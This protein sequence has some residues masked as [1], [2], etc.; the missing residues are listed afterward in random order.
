MWPLLQDF[1]FAWRALRRSPIHS[2]S[3]I[4]TMALGI[5]SATAIFAIVYG[6]LLR[7]LPFD[8]ADRVVQVCEISQPTA[9]FCVVSP[10][11]LADLTRDAATIEAAGVA[12]GQ[13]LVGEDASG[14]YSVRGGLATPGLFRV[15]ALRPAMGRLLE[16]IDMPRGANQVVVVSHGF[17]QSRLGGSANAVGATIRLDGRDVRVLGVL[18]AGAYFPPVERGGLQGIDDP[19]QRAWRGF[20]ALARTKAG[21][22]RAAAA[23]ELAARYT[24]LGVAYPDANTGWTLRIDGLRERL[25]GPVRQ[26]LWLFQAAVILVLLI[27]CANVASLIMVRGTAREAEFAI[28]WSLGA[29]RAR[30]L[31]QL[32]AE[33]LLLSLAGAAA[34]LPL[35]AAATRV[36]IDI[37]PRDIPR[38]SEVTI[39]GSVALFAMVLALVTAVLFGLLPTR[40]HWGRSAGALRSHRIV[41]GRQRLRS[42]L[43][44]LEL[45]LALAL[46]VGASLTLRAYGRLSVWNPG[47][48][49]SGLNISWMFAPPD[50]FKTTAGAVEALARV[51]DA[52]AGIPGIAS[53]GLASA[54]ALFGGEEAGELKLADR[55][56][57]EGRRVLW[58]D[59]D[60]HYFGTL[61]LRPTLGRLITSEDTGG[62]A[63]VAVINDTLA[64][65]VFGDASPLGRRVSVGT[66]VSEIV[67]VVPTLIPA[68]PDKPAAPEIYWPI[69]QYRRYAAYLVVRIEPGATGL[70]PAI[71]ARAGAAAGA[72]QLTPLVSLETIFDRT[73]VSPR[74]NMWLIAV[75][76]SV[77]IT[78][79]VIGVYGVMAFAVSSRTRD[80]G[81]RIALG[82]SPGRVTAEFLRSSLRLVALGT[83]GGVLL[84]LGLARWF[85]SLLFGVPAADWPV[86]SI[87]LAGF[88]AVAT[89]AAY[90]PA[91]RA[92]RVDPLQALRI[93]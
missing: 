57:D 33:G 83:A 4:G 22:S 32:V 47:F 69:R 77:A 31:R 92:S 63:Q 88:A 34:G 38:L 43:V 66:Y 24:Q 10:P 46:V 73:L 79:A 55:A 20:L 44:I 13:A 16:D 21:V 41:E 59:L 78:L 67:G 27:A 74:F 11:N 65:Q 15:L 75:F 26:T 40:R 81:V 85:S 70:E 89:L 56:G 87:A 64:R 8:G 48:D 2:L 5:G 86:I 72:V 84:A 9:A 28:R 37:A 19:E 36:L 6:V 17:W 71:R 76:A 25:T 49:R 1:R 80:I 52:V 50:V 90:L 39:D 14:R 42:A 58:Y 45:A 61:G 54:G 29:N 7:P 51:R 60:E 18:P 53:V 23:R 35:S 93:D 62:S 91:R 68:R 3:V 30:I 12:R 82:A